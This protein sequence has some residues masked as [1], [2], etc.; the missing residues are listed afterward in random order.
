MRACKKES[1]NKNKNKKQTRKIKNFDDKKIKQNKLI[2]FKQTKKKSSRKCEILLYF[3][4]KQVYIQKIYMMAAEPPR[5]YTSTC[6]HF[7]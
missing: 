2:I 1:K 6:T 4:I 7:H 5:R 3:R